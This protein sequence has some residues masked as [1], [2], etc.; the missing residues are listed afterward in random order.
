MKTIVKYI[1]L[2]S[3]EYQLGSPL[4]EVELNESADYFDQ[5]PDIIEH[6]NHKFK[7]LSKELSRKKTLDDDIEEVQQIV[8][9]MVAFVA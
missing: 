6:Q 3:K 7:V 5:I 1:V 4:P 2:K 9:K 8:I